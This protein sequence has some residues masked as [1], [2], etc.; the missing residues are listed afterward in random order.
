[1]PIDAACLPSCQLTDLVKSWNVSASM[2]GPYVATI[3]IED[4]CNNFTCTA[5]NEELFKPVYMKLNS[6]VFQNWGL[7]DACF[8]RNVLWVNG[9]LT[10]IEKSRTETGFSAN[11]SVKSYF[12]RLSRKVINSHHGEDSAREVLENLASLYATLPDA[13]YDFSETAND[14]V[15]GPVSGNSLLGEMHLLAQAGRSYLFTNQNG[16]LVTKAWYDPDAAV[17]L[18]IPSQFVMSA[19]RSTA[20][21][22]VPTRV[23]V[24]GA[25]YT[26]LEKGIRDL[27]GGGGGGGGNGQQKKETICAKNP[28]EDSEL[29]FLFNS[30]QGGL[31]DLRNAAIELEDG[32]LAPVASVNLSPRQLSVFINGESGNYLGAGDKTL[33]MRVVGRVRDPRE[34]EPQRRGRG[35]LGTGI[36]DPNRYIAMFPYLV[37]SMYPGISL[38]SAAAGGGGGTSQVS[39]ETDVPDILRKEMVVTDP[40]LKDEL[41]VVTHELDN[42]YVRDKEKLFDIAVQYFQESKMNREPWNINLAYVPCVEIGQKVQIELPETM[43]GGGCTI[44]GQISQ[45]KVSYSEGPE[46]MT[47]LVVLPEDAVGDTRYSSEN[48]LDDPDLL[49]YGERWNFTADENSSVYIY[50]GEAIV[51]SFAGENAELTLDQPYATIGRQYEISFDA[52][53]VEPGNLTFEVR[54][55]DDTVISSMTISGSGRYALNFTSTDT[56][57]KF[58]WA[59]GSG[60]DIKWIIKQPDLRTEVIG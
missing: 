10:G 16:Y 33:S 21:E 45:I 37:A 44:V 47:Q 34:Y 25:Y 43:E 51:F 19:S 39:G 13:L 40:D 14:D 52:E 58:S 24:R 4:P 5:R 12:A 35:I 59:C 22:I 20:P 30:L 28:F 46:A 8:N 11:L 36:F 6:Q 3:E 23:M 9:L 31:A 57:L 42:R 15:V 29:N 41:G 54:K 56:A 32:Q 17:D 49:G 48:L 55:A 7:D 18:V 26:S 60:S 50:Q 27:S 53:A 2:G 38:T 1:M